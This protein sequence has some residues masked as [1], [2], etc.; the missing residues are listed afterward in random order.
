[1]FTRDILLESKGGFL[2]KKSDCLTIQSWFPAACMLTIPQVSQAYIGPGAGL[3]A[4]GSFIALVFALLVAIV[5]FVWY[6]TKRILKKRGKVTETTSTTE[7]ERNIV[8]A[9]NTNKQ[10]GKFG[11]RADTN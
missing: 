9:T 2:M 4:I 3:T 5:G 6:P 7:E 1:L 11:E 10:E 8:E